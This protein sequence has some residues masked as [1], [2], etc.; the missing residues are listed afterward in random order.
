MTSEDLN[1]GNKEIVIGTITY[2]LEELSIERTLRLTDMVVVLLETLSGSIQEEFSSWAI[3]YGAENG[4]ELTAEDVKTADDETKEQ[5]IRLGYDL[6]NIDGSVFIAGQPSEAEIV[7][8]FFPNI[9]KV[10]RPQILPA[11]A[12]IL[13]S[14]KDM[15]KAE[16]EEGG[17]DAYLKRIG[18]T[19]KHEGRTKDLVDLCVLTYNVARA[20]MDQARAEGN[21][22]PALA[23]LFQNS[24]DQSP[25]DE[26]TASISSPTDTTGQEQKLSTEPSGQTS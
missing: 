3:T 21:L 4:I 12:L 24:Q 19:I 23:G 9:W 17:I 5:L 15:A 7:G 26:Q 25:S 20:E 18:K 10:A 16:D 2:K 6:E 13:A 11:F 14:N 22:H 1:I 8:W